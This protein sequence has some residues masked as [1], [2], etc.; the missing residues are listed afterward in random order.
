MTAVAWEITHSVQTNASPTF[1]WHY[2]SN[3]GNWD[4]PPAEFELDEPF[5]TGSRG[6]T[7]LPGQE[8]LHWLLQDVTPPNAAT[9]QLSLDGATLL[10]HWRFVALTHGGTEV[11]QRIVLKGEKTELYLPQ[12]TSAFTANPPQAMAKL[13]LAMANAESESQ[14]V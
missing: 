8:P 4:D 6:V 13:A 9:I 3:V 2:W 10:F 14:I 11:T 12:V 7:R 1:A 5:A